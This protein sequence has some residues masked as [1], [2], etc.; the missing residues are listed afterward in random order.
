M[1]KQEKNT[2][3]FIL[4]GVTSMLI[5]G[6]IFIAAYALKTILDTF[7][8]SDPTL[9]TLSYKSVQ[10]LAASIILTL[11][12][13]S[14]FTLYSS[15]KKISEKLKENLWTL[16]TK[17][18]VKNFVIGMLVISLSLIVLVQ[19]DFFSFLTPIF[20]LFYGILLFFL[21]NKKR[22]DFLMLSGL[23]VLLGLLCFLIPSYWYSS[24]T[25]LGIAHITYG[26]V[27]KE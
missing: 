26:V 24:L 7:L 5:G 22:K 8:V 3:A 14:A 19:F 9:E 25:I 15:G 18:I 11:L 21:K 2:N 12:I 16:Q 20:L 10:L 1:E 4:K 27:V 23:S 13:L 17:A 6:Y